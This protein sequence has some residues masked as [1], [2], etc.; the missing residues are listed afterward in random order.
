MKKKVKKLETVKAF[1]TK[2]K[3][4]IDENLKGKKIKQEGITKVIKK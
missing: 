2:A 3:Y 1:D 4:E